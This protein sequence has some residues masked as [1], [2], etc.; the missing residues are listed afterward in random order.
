MFRLHPSKQ[1]VRS[2]MLSQNISILIKHHFD[3]EQLN[4]NICIW[5][6]NSIRP[7][8]PDWMWKWDG[9]GVSGMGLMG[10]G[11]VSAVPAPGPSPVPLTQRAGAVSTMLLNPS[12]SPSGQGTPSAAH[13]T[14]PSTRSPSK[15]FQGKINHQ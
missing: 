8:E 1:F 12:S 15:H 6:L 14:K 2:D 13:T 9:G 3:R 5:L 11:W 7:V 10:W 4:P